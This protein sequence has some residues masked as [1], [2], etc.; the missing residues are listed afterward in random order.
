MQPIVSTKVFIR[1]LHCTGNVG[2]LC[3]SR[4]RQNV[5][6]L[7]MERISHVA[8]TTL[9]AEKL[10]CSCVSFVYKIV[11]IVCVRVTMLCSFSLK[12]KFASQNCLR[13]G[14]EIDI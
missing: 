11:F 5:K 14:F 3:E 10:F 12:L 4:G 6:M 1:N 8:G 7:K 2:I 9:C 13:T